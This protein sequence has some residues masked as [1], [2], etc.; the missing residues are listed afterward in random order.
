MIRQLLARHRHDSALSQLIAEA[1]A[2]AEEAIRLEPAQPKYRC[3][4]GGSGG[5]AAEKHDAR[6]KTTL[7]GERARSHGEP[8]ADDF[9]RWGWVV[10]VDVGAARSL[11]QGRLS[12]ADT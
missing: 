2:D 10:G 11:G 3:R 9:K 6:R 1:Q 8:H 4:L 5:G 7:L 12:A